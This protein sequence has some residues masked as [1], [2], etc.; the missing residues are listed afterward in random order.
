MI[1]TCPRCST[2][3]L[4]EAGVIQPPGRQVRC[5]RCQNTW[6]QD[7]APDLPKPVIIEEPPAPTGPVTDK[8]RMLPPPPG[9][10]SQPIP[11]VEPTMGAGAGALPRP[12]PEPRRGYGFMA[13]ALLI[14][15]LLAGVG[16]TVVSLPNEVTTLFPKMAWVYEMMGMPVNTR[17]FRIEAR[18]T[19]ELDKGVPVIAITGEIINE[20]SDELPVPKVALKVRDQAGRELYKWTVIPDPPKLAGHQRAPFTA[21]LESPPADAFDIEIRFA[22]PGE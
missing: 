2:R 17:G 15:A 8:S 19:Q 3:Y 6:F 16:L 22:K 5:A 4:L 13:A 21:R 14:V 1:I 7:A 10:I 9:S 18:H 11:R 20:T 12:T